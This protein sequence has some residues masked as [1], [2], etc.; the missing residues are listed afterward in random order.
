MSNDLTPQ[1]MRQLTRK[2]VQRI[3]GLMMASPMTK[4]DVQEFDGIKP[5]LEMTEKGNLTLGSKI[6]ANIAKQAHNGD[7]KSAELLLK[8]GGFTPAVETQVEVTLP[9][10]VDDVTIERNITDE[11]VAE[12]PKVLSPPNEIKTPKKKED[13]IT[14]TEDVKVIDITRWGE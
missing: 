9:T 3:I 12:E 6:L 2:D 1:E 8:Y 11:V 14:D 5:F 10:F 4:G 7:V 13:I